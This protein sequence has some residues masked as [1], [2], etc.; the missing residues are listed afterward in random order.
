M[1]KLICGFLCVAVGVALADVESVVATIEVRAITSSLTNTIVAIPGLDL[2]TG[3]ALA[4]SNLVKT[5]NL[6]AGDKLVAFDGN[7]Y[8]TWVL[9][10]TGGKHWVKTAQK[11]TISAVAVEEN[12]G[13]PASLYTM[14]V[15]KGI[16]LSRTAS[17]TSSPFYVY[18]QQPATTSTTVAAKETALVGNP[19]Q[20]NRIPTIATPEEGDQVVVPKSGMP[21]T[22]T[23]KGSS[24]KVQSGW[25]GETT[26]SL[27]TIPAGTG[28]WY[29]S[30]SNSVNGVTISWPAP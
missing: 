21:V 26:A 20:S 8:E 10:E 29:V 6:A 18:A 3:D 27:P 22:Y 23:Y 25:S 7:T 4:I 2:A 24:W 30:N 19:T 9:S 13:T 1:K 15:G 12:T 14:P 28:F 17:G 11:I 5:T 16:W